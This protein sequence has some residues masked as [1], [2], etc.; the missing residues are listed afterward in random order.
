M[1]KVIMVGPARNVKGGMST[2]VNNY[3]NYGL[4]HDFN[5]KYVETINDGNKINKFIKEK[6]GFL[7][8]LFN[9]K[10]NDIVHIHMA[11]RRSTFRKIMYIKISKF[12]KKKIVLHIHGGGFK[13]FFDEECNI[14]QKKYIKKY[15]N[16]CD[17]IIVLSEEWFEYFKYLVDRSK[18]CVIYNGVDVP[19]KKEKE[20]IDKNILFLGRIE[21]DKGIYELID[22]I[23]VLV[24]KDPDVKLYIG[25]S[26]ESNRLN[27][28][29][30]NYKLEKNVIL[31]G[32]I[33]DEEKKKYFE[34]CSYFI[35]PSYFEAMPMSLLEA[36]ANSCVVIATNVGGIPHVINNRIN[37]ILINPKKI[38]EIVKVVDEL[39][40]NKKLNLT[41]SNNAYLTVLEKFNING[42]IDSI[43]KIYYELI[44]RDYNEK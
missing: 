33:N 12:F 8:F 39:F 19:S 7:T 42:N 41:L 6:L 40:D 23:N 17:K 11:S 31:L 27:E 13:K 35:L 5:L 10:K 32:W 44:E 15:L 21:K 38:D 26:G 1:I 34:L 22:A 36:M 14:K 2:V 24:K 29:I 30:K 43:K 16:Y 28:V 37:G 18:I 9:I 3:F 4:D 25:G 20:F